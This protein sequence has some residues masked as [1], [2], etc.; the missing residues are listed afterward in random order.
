M[1]TPERLVLQNYCQHTFLDIDLSESLH[2]IIGENGRGKS[3]ILN[4]I[5]FALTGLATPGAHSLDDDILDGADT[6]I[7]SLDFKLPSGERGTIQRTLKRRS[8]NNCILTLGGHTIEGA[9]RC[10]ERLQEI[11]GNDIK[12]V[13][14]T[15][16][17]GQHDISA[18]LLAGQPAKRLQKLQTLLLGD[19]FSNALDAVAQEKSKLYIDENIQNTVKSDKKTLSEHKKIAKT[20]QSQVNTLTR[21]LDSKKLQSLKEKAGKISEYTQLVERWVSLNTEEIDTKLKLADLKKELTT[22]GKLPDLDKLQKTVLELKE[23]RLA[24]LEYNNQKEQR[25]A[26]SAELAKL[27]A[28]QKSIEQ[29]EATY[30]DIAQKEQDRQKALE[31]YKLL[32]TISENTQKLQDL[33]TTGDKGSLETNKLNE[34]SNKL[35]AELISYE[36]RLG[37]L[38]QFL[39]TDKMSSTCPICSGQISPERRTQLALEFSGLF[40][41][42]ND[43]QDKLAKLTSQLNDNV[44]KTMSL[45]MESQKLTSDI[46]NASV[47]LTTL[48][49]PTEPKDYY[50]SLKLPE[51]QSKAQELAHVSGQVFGLQSQLAELNKK[52]ISVPKHSYNEEA[53][54]LAE[55]AYT[56]AL[57]LKKQLDSK[58]VEITTYTGKLTLAKS[59]KEQ[60]ESI[61]KEKELPKLD[62]GAGFKLT[63]EEEEYLQQALAKEKEL[64]DVETQLVATNTYIQAL[65]E[66]ISNAESAV[67]GVVAT[68][69]YSTYLTKLGKV[70]KVLPNTILQHQLADLCRSMQEIIATFHFY[71]PF[72]VMVNDKLEF[73]LKYPNKVVRPIKKASGGEQI[74]LGIAFRLAAHKKF[75]TLDWLAIDEPTNHLT[76]ANIKVLQQ[77]IS[78]LKGNL[79]LYGIKKLIIATHSPLLVNSDAHIINL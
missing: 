28:L 45:H 9:E 6:A 69:D 71:Q 7:V 67:D 77:V 76:D 17:V 35:K 20:L 12:A 72:G 79:G 68:K 55:K 27:T 24:W 63:P 66:R 59:A 3:N 5:V 4:A 2:I 32:D 70:L 15:V 74:I 61:A 51:V 54:Q 58:N 43:I 62:I 26:L 42:V 14:N 18:L 13:M 73:Q 10:Q 44:N 52:Q 47:Q 19:I 31:Y 30:K 37:I 38:K 40:N 57:N 53:L 25:N 23:L 75:S 39:D 64:K 29:A 8:G 11:L 16:V 34:E 56:D 21:T 36:G 49:K 65:E 33:K 1:F 48:S 60:L 78:H 41:K 22:L 46:T 50:T